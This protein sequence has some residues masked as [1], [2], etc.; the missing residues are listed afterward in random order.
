[1]PF[2]EHLE[3]LR[4]RLIYALLSLVPVFVL[5]LTFGTTLLDVILW[6]AQAQ[7]RAAELP[8]MLQATGPLETFAA[9]VKV[10]MAATLVIG[11]PVALYQLWLFIAPGLYAHERRFARFLVPLSMVLS[12]LGLVFMYFVL[13]PAML[14]FMLHFGAGVGKPQVAVAEPLPGVVFQMFPVLAADPPN[15]PP[16]AIWFNQSLQELRMNVA[17]PATDD[18]PVPPQIRGTPMTRAAGIAQQY[19]ISQYLMLVFN[20]SIAVALGFQMPV[21]VLLLGWG[22]LV[23]PEALRKHRRY[24][25]LICAI[26]A[27]ILTPPDPLSLFLLTVPLWLLYEFGVLLLTW[28]PPSRVAS[29]VFRRGQPRREPPDIGDE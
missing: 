9:W 21:A 19:R 10:S 7:L 12:A 28:L 27:A 6:P 11:V 16:G 23:T 29:G 22:G 2:G 24:A 14:A 25:I 17:A 20:M 5:C 15:P 3:E 26:V 4:R 1:M 13:L 18:R 8:V